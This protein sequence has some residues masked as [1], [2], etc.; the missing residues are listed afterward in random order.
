MAKRQKN[1]TKSPI[2]N[3]NRQANDFKFG[4][5]TNVGTADATNDRLLSDTFYDNGAFEL[6]LSVDSPESLI[7]GRTGSGK[8]ALVERLI[9]RKN[10]VININPDHLSL[11][12]LVDSTLLRFFHDSGVKMDI[13]YRLL[14]NHIF[15]VEILKARYNIDNEIS[16]AGILQ[17][18]ADLVTG[19]KGRSEAVN[20]LLDWGDKF[21]LGTEARVK[22][23]I[24][25]LETQVQES[26]GADAKAAFP[27]IVDIT[28]KAEHK[29]D[30]TV[31]EEVKTEIVNR[32]R[33]VV[34]RIQTQRI[35]ELIRLLEDEILHDKQKPFYITIDRLDENWVND[36][37]RYQLIKSL[38]EVSRDLNNKVTN[39]KVCIALRQD[40]IAR[41]FKLTQDSGFQEEKFRDLYVNLYWSPHELQNM[42]ELRMNK[43]ISSRPTSR[44]ITMD[45]IITNSVNGE[46]PLD[47]M[48]ARTMLR[49]RDLIVFFN[50]SIKCAA[51]KS[52]IAAQDIIQA[53]IE[54]S[55]SRYDALQYEW[56]N[57]YP[58]LKNLIGFMRRYPASFTIPEI[59][60]RFRDSALEFFTRSTTQQDIIYSIINDT[61]ADKEPTTVIE[62]SIEIL[63]KVGVLGIRPVQQNH[64]HWSFKR[65]FNSQPPFQVKSV[66]Y[67]HPC[68]WSALSIKYASVKHGIT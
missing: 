67:I 6:I 2:I 51:G 65:Q 27:K 44:I 10:H 60:D 31:S 55:Q 24:N 18:F 40:L 47:Y 59:Q 38:I 58:N 61:Y 53:E 48:I 62:K 26:I 12:Y 22:E 37:L 29:N 21:W 3:V 57:D 36:D 68:L 34:S 43:V 56:N 11:G 9:E 23:V 14:W 7:V 17:R 33:D 39:L 45:D 28:A 66:Y 64:V 19:N 35:Q 54:Y 46:K 13:F 20:Y 8:T 41:V 5:N 15:I 50:E 42:I 49:P 30:Y 63:F 4:G 52:S 32:G 16:R 25:K 1:K